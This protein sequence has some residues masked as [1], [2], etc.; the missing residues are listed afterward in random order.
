[1]LD[2]LKTSYLFIPLFI[3][4]IGIG[5]CGSSKIA[6]D[7]MIFEENPPFTIENAYFQKWVAG[8]EEGGS[9]TKVHLTFRSMEPNV[10]IK[11]I[12]FQNQ[13]IK[14]QKSSANPRE[15]TADFPNSSRND[16]VMDIDPVKEAANTPSGNFPF[17]LNKNEAVLGYLFNGKENFYKISHLSEKEHLA[18]PQSNPN[19]PN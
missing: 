7:K 16:I 8:I 14:A 9:G 5:S 13:I 19:N 12:Y 2:L 18:Y 3:L 11:N 4:S 10:V 1:M 17:E 6:D 15:Y